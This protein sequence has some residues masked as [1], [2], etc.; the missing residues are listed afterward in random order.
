MK[1]TVEQ[2]QAIYTK[3]CN[4][5]VIMAPVKDFIESEAEAEVNEAYDY[6]Y[7]ME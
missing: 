6:N 1:W 2:E 7:L 4:L 3:D 5:L